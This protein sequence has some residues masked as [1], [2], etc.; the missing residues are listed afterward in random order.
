[1][2]IVGSILGGGPPM[3]AALYFDYADWLATFPE[4]V[5]SY[6]KFTMLF[7]AFAFLFGGFWVA[8]KLYQQ[9]FLLSSDA[10]NN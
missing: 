2:S 10:D 1:M 6:V 7:F 3:A 5:T 8:D 9:L 4:S